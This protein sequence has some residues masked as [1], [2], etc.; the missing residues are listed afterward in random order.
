MTPDPN[1]RP[2]SPGLVALAQLDFALEPATAWPGLRGHSN[3]IACLKWAEWM[4]RTKGMS[5]AR[6]NLHRSIHRAWWDRQ[7]GTASNPAGT[8]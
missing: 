3:H 1:L 5:G 7:A 4:R 8:E 6:R 2:A